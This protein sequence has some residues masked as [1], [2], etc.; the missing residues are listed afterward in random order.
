[1]RYW[2]PSNQCS[3]T[4]PCIKGFPSKLFY[5]YLQKFISKWYKK[6][7]Q[8]F[9]IVLKLLLVVGK[10]KIQPSSCAGF[11]SLHQPPFRAVWSSCH[12]SLEH[13]PKMKMQSS[14]E[15][16]PSDNSLPLS[17]AVLL[18]KYQIRCGPCCN[19]PAVLWAQKIFS[20][21]TV[22]WDKHWS[23]AKYG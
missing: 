22:R 15:H 18:W 23:C 3:Y 12:L 17:S 16:L 20:I 4:M 14:Q 19:G 21:Q 7:R 1:M 2:G 10:P 13:I 5:N 11:G 8:I 9:R 6:T